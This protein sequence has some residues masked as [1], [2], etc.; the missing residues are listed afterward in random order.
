MSLGATGT[1]TTYLLHQRFRYEYPTPVR[2]LVHRL[3]VV[4][5]HLHGDQRRLA[6][7]LEVQ[8][9]PARRVSWLDSFGNLVVE[10][11]APAVP[12]AI[13]F[14]SWVVVER[15]RRPDA[16]AP[17]D[18]AL[19]DPRL[20]APSRLTRPDAPLLEGARR[21][22]ADRPPPLVMA[23][24]INHWV[25][26]ALRYSHGVTHVRTTAAQALALG[27]GV[28]QDYAHVMLAVSRLC[29]LPARY[30]SGHLVGEGGSHAWVEVALPDPEVPGQRWAL[31]F[32]PTHDRRA[33]SGY[34]TVAVGRDYSDVAPTSGTFQARCTGRLHCRKHLQVAVPEALAAS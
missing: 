14:E 25:H 2:H 34:V 28:C 15:G 30:V 5:P 8:G 22:A 26:R 23:E 6:S 13:E 7:R 31:A 18:V 3:V 24:R 19:Q 11:R 27:Q 12:E 10:V 16:P 9:A 21:L 32:D 29:G 4:P 33:G 20:V 17:A 1:A